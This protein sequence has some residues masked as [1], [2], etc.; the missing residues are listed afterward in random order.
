MFCE[1]NVF[2]Q[3]VTR[4]YVPI[5]N[6]SSLDKLRWYYDEMNGAVD[7]EREKF[8][9]VISHLGSWGAL[10]LC[11]LVAL[12]V[13]VCTVNCLVFFLLHRYYCCGWSVEV[14]LTV[15]SLC[16]K[17]EPFVTRCFVFVVHIYILY[18]SS[19]NV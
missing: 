16:C 15:P 1:A 4:S 11:V 5:Y 12:R 6:E 19:N 9:I 8:L 3:T 7:G 2:M 13:L 17:S 14:V 18:I 10:S